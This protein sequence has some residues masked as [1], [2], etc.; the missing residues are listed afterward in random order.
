MTN[1]YWELFGCQALQSI[2]NI[3]LNPHITSM[4][5]AL[6]LSHFL[7]EEI[8]AQGRLVVQGLIDSE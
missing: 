4:R 3:T 7:G 2:N 8:V 1:I 5:Y 6:L